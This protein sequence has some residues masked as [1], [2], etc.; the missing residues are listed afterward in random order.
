MKYAFLAVTVMGIAIGLAW[1]GAK[2]KAAPPPVLAA[3]VTDQPRDTVLDR[4][5]SGHFFTVADVNGEPI[6]FVVDT[7][8]TTVALTEDDARRAGVQFDP[9]QFDVVGSG[10]SGPVRGQEVQL[11][12]VELDG[13]RVSDIHALVLDG[14]TVSLLG[15]NYLRHLDS[16]SISGD[17]MTLR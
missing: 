4:E 14:L 9:S 10:A 12:D 2:P 17:K 16:V 3:A 6:K 13:K 7:G 5:D 1:P 8:A 11:K 15:Q